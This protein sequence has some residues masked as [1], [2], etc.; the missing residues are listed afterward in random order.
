METL[1]ISS[2]HII[3]NIKKKEYPIRKR[4][5]GMSMDA[6]LLLAPSYVFVVGSLLFF[7][8]MLSYSL[9]ISLFSFVYKGFFVTLL[10]LYPLLCACSQCGSLGKQ[11]MGLCVVDKHGKALS[12]KQRWMRVFLGQALPIFLA[13]WI[14]Q[15][16]GVVSVMGMLM[17]FYIWTPQHKSFIDLLLSTS[18]VAQKKENTFSL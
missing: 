14:A 11:W 2:R 12:F 7:C 15:G 13:G 16:R 1:Q 8:R 18:I 3:K 4:I 17:L 9:Y 6:A 10:I 5:M